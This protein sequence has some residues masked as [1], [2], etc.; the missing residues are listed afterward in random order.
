M[1]HYSAAARAKQN[2][3]DAQDWVYETIG[4]YCANKATIDTQIAGI[5]TEVKSCMEYIVDRSCSRR[6]RHGRVVF[7]EDQHQALKDCCGRYLIVVCRE[8]NDFETEP[9]EVATSFDLAPDTV[10]R[11]CQAGFQRKGISWKILSKAG[12]SR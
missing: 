12:G 3:A 10:D 1:N 2:G 7:R 6:R 8:R 4:A 9:L 11:L 5:P